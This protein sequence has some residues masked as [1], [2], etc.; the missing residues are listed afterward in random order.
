MI[1]PASTPSPLRARRPVPAR[2]LEVAAAPLSLAYYADDFTGATDVLEQVALAGLR[3]RLFLRTPTPAQLA[4]EP[5]LQVAGVAGVARALAP[6]AMKRELRAAFTALRGLGAPHVH[7]KVCSTFDSSPEV[8]SIGCALDLGAEI[9]QS[10]FVPVLGGAPG[11]GRFCAFGNLFARY[12][13]GSAGPIHRLDRHPS[14]SRHPVTPM[15]EADLR[16]H[17][18]QQTRRQ[19]GLVDFLALDGSELEVRTA[20]DSRLAAGDEIVLFD[21]LDAAHLARIGALLFPLGSSQRPLFSVGS[22][23]VEAALFAGRHGTGVRPFHRSSAATLALSG[24]CSPVTCEQIEWARANGLLVVPFERGSPPDATVISALRAGRTTIVYTSL[25]APAGAPWPA[26]QLGRALGAFARRV[27]PQT[28]V[29]RLVIAGGDTASYT[30]R[31]LGVEELELQS[32]LVPGAPLCRASIPRDPL[33][34][35]ELVCKGG[36]VGAADFFATAAAGASLS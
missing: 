16:R 5:D 21:T 15:I 9:F 31:A 2:A 25:G 35:L 36:Q 33:D 28:C 1:P 19:I 23:A 20:L 18:A 6:A 14:V 11:L 17:L 34:G 22:S 10:R 30:A 4:R 7:Y 27:L 13:I 8:G 12:G 3:A 29:R 26:P 24:S 32:P